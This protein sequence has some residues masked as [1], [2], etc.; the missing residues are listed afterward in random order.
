[1]VDSQGWF[2]VHQTV[3]VGPFPYAAAALEYADAQRGG[4]KGWTIEFRGKPDNLISAAQRV[5]DA[6][7]G[8][9]PDWL[10]LELAA[11][12]TAL[13]ELRHGG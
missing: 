6:F 5:L 10:K 3:S 8:D 7:G 2:A 13:E 9:W 4:R 12:E 1:M 11:L